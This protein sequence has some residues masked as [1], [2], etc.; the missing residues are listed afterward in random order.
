VDVPD[1]DLAKMPLGFYVPLADADLDPGLLDLAVRAFQAAEEVSK[2]YY[3]GPWPTGWDPAG[4]V[5]ASCK[6]NATVFASGPY[7][8]VGIQEGTLP[9]GLDWPVGGVVGGIGN[10]IRVTVPAHSVT[11]GPITGTRPY[12]ERLYGL[13]LTKGPRDMLLDL[14]AMGVRDW[15]PL[16]EFFERLLTLANRAKAII[17]EA[18]EQARRARELAA[19]R[20]AGLEEP[21]RD[22]VIEATARRI[23]GVKVKGS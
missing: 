15:K 8:G 1:E 21:D 5:M 12:E 6:V 18:R 4:D 7:R 16:A 13:T 19:R 17:A 10:G 9:L 11:E 22:P 23:A 2:A 20:L 14:K 3:A